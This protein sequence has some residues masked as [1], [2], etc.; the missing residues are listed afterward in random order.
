MIALDI[1]TQLNNNPP[2]RRDNFN[3][4]SSFVSSRG[5]FVIHSG[6]HR[7]TAF[8]GPEFEESFNSATFWLRQSQPAVNAWIETIID[9]GEPSQAEHEAC[10][11]AFPDW[12]IEK[13]VGKGSQGNSGVIA[14]RETPG[15]VERIGGVDWRDLY[16]RLT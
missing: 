1:L 5:G 11:R 8:V 2:V 10:K 15:G 6:I 9:G 14:W 7:S 4:D 16:T 13:G 3:R 12:N